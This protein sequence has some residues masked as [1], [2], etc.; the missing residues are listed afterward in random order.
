M[1]RL[2]QVRIEV[3][4]AGEFQLG[5]TQ[6]KPNLALRRPL[7]RGEHSTNIFFPTAG[8]RATLSLMTKI[9]F[10]GFPTCACA[11]DPGQASQAG[12]PASPVR[13]LNRLLSRYG[14][15]AIKEILPDSPHNPLICPDSRSEMEGKGTTFSRHAARKTRSRRVACAFWKHRPLRLSRRPKG[16][17]SRISGRR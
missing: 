8:V 12:G 3:T 2:R 10:G 15:G 7:L 4:L 5:L 17:G 11:L 9:D 6:P 14:E 13:L 1:T 16:G